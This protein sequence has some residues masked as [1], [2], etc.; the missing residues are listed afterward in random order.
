MNRLDDLIAG[1]LGHGSTWL[2]VLV[3]ILL[4][5]RHATDP[6]HLVAVSTLI[7]SEESNRYRRALRL[8]LA[9]GCGHGLALLVLGGA[10]VVFGAELPP[11]VVTVAEACVGLIVIAL[12][13]R[14]LVR[15]RRGGFV[16]HRHGLPLH[17]HPVRGRWQA[18]AIGVVHGTGGSAGVSVLVLA[19]ISDHRLALVAL[20]LF[21]AGTA[22]SMALASLCFA[23]G[24]A[25]PR[26]Q[27]RLLPLMGCGGVA[28]GSFYLLS[29]LG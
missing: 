3:A 12:A 29:A 23:R 17:T 27:Q 11:A 25:S 14:L 22:L 6:D 28:F 2:T 1:S 8:G 24:L 20:A 5:L 18:F 21:A 26:R 15:V 16:E 13:L 9:W 19:R 4:G 10:V 7:A